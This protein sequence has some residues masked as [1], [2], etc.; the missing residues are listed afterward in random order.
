M[1]APNACFKHLIQTPADSHFF[2]V[3]K[4]GSGVVFLALHLFIKSSF[5]CQIWIETL[6][7]G[8]GRP[9]R[10]LNKRLP[11]QFRRSLSKIDAFANHGREPV[12]SLK[13]IFLAKIEHFPPDRLGVFGSPPRGKFKLIFFCQ[14]VWDIGGSRRGHI[15]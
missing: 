9:K 8:L 7:E 6:L 4:A 5:F 2:V 14:S 11:T 10:L 3:F 12:R 13:R 15:S 1:P